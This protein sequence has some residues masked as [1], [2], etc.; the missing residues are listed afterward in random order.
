VKLIFWVGD[1]D[2]NRKILIG[3]QDKSTNLELRAV[4]YKQ[5]INCLKRILTTSFPE[6]I[7]Q[8]E[9]PSVI[10]NTDRYFDRVYFFFKISMPIIIFA[11][12][13]P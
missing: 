5:H 7:V 2:S 12:S 9:I 10:M 13:D 8:T 4:E 3:C 1:Y 6:I 11:I